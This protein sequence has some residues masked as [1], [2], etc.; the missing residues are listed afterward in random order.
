MIHRMT[1]TND[2]YKKPLTS[3]SLVD[4][5]L[6]LEPT[7]RIGWTDGVVIHDD[8]DILEPE[9]AEAFGASVLESLTA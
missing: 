6:P 5:T 7:R 1:K 2:K 3:E 8:F 4:P 9:I